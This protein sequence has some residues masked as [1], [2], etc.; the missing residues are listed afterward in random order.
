[1]KN[2]E[3]IKDYYVFDTSALLTDPA[4]LN[5]FPDSILVIP[6][7][8]IVELDSKKNRIDEVGKSARYLH[9]YLYGLTKLGDLSSGVV[10]ENS[11]CTIMCILEDDKD[12]P[13]CLDKSVVDNRILSVCITLNKLNKKSK[14]TLVTNDYNL[15]LKAAIYKINNIEFKGAGIID[16]KGY[17][18]YRTIK[19]TSTL[20]SEVFKKSGNVVDLVKNTKYKFNPNECVYIKKE[21]KTHKNVVAIFKN[22]KLHKLHENLKFLSIE[23]QNIEQ[24]MLFN[25]LADPDIKLITV[26]G[27]AG[28][29]KTVCAVSAG[30]M[31]IMGKEPRYDKM[32]LSRS[33]EPLSGKDRIGFLKGSLDDKLAPYILPLKDS[34]DFVLSGLKPALD[35]K[36]LKDLNDKIEIEPLQFIRGRSIRQAFFIVDEAQNLTRKQV[37]AIITRIGEGSKIV[38][39]GDTDFNQID[40]IYVNSK[41][42]GLSQTIEAFKTSKLAAHVE[43]R[44]GIR[45]EL[46]SECTERL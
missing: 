44:E 37:K 29:G 38:L 7:S 30:L 4:C 27:I 9:K 25:Y 20:N 15:S 46:A 35:V 41:T 33:L 18:G 26:N 24:L 28:C 31:Q 19:S 32:I 10:D 23:P 12:V 43:L 14:V 2:S 1:M 39:L 6:I 8:V 11:K 16:T 45:S 21:V 5:T 40:N 3:S 36:T 22:N 34:I 42:N 17:K 13:P